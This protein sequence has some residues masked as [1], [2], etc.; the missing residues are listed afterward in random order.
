M[1]NLSGFLNRLLIL[2]ASLVYSSYG[3][4]SQCYTPSLKEKTETADLIL[5]GKIEST[6]ED[7]TGY[8]AAVLKVD[9][10]KKG[11][12]TKKELTVYA[13][14]VWVKDKKIAGFRKKKEGDKPPPG[15]FPT[16]EYG[17]GFKR[18]YRFFLTRHNKIDGAFE[19]VSCNTSESISKEPKVKMEK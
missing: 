8:I 6:I 5:E 15:F 19:P 9:Q 17:V 10:I 13:L 11:A 14:P 2:T 3:L 4:A 12:L 1:N 16:T 7:D 18:P